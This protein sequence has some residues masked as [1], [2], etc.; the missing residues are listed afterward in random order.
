MGVRPCFIIGTTDYISYIKR[1]GFKWECNDL[2]SEDSGRTLD[3][4]MHRSRVSQKRKLTI[5]LVPLKTEDFATI[6]SAIAD[7][8]V[9]IKI[10]DPKAGAQVTY[11]FYGSS[12]KSAVMSDDGTDC[13]WSDGE[14]SIVE[15]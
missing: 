13:W 2:D 12:I 4:V 7:E 6:S 3:G 9:D 1:D 15:Q 10:L 5:S 8:Y 14:F 11:T